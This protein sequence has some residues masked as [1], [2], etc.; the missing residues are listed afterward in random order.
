M[1]CLRAVVMIPV[2][3]VA[4]NASAQVTEVLSVDSHGIYGNYHSWY[5]SFAANDRFVAFGSQATNLVPGDTNGFADV[6]VRDRLQGT[7]ERASVGSAGRQGDGHSVSSSISGTGRWVAFASAA[8][9]LVPGDTNR[10]MDVFVRDRESGATERISVDP[11]GVQSDGDSLAPAIS[12]D[13]RFVAFVSAATNLVAGDTNAVADVFVRDLATGRTERISVD[14]S[15]MEGNQASGVNTPS[16][17]ADGR[18]VAFDSLARNLVSGDSNGVCD[19]FVRDRRL[20]VT[21]RVSVASN[22]WQGNRQSATPSISADGRFVAFAGD[23]TNLVTTDRGF[24]WDVFLHDRSSGTTERLS[25]APSGIQG[26]DHSGS[27]EISADGRSVAFVSFA[28]NLDPR[29]NVW[30][31]NIYVRDLVRDVT[32]LAS[33]GVDGTQASCCS[34]QYGLAVSADGRFVAFESDAQD[35]VPAYLGGAQVYIRDRDALGFTSLCAPGV[36][37]VTPCPCSNPASQMGPGCDNSAGTGGALLTAAGIAYVSRDELTFSTRGETPTALSV[38]VQADDEFATGAVYGQG[39]RCGV[40]PLRRLFTRS[41]V[42]GSIRVPDPQAGDPSVT[43][44]SAAVGSAIQAGES[45]W[46][47]VYYRDPVVL[48]GCPPTSVFNVTQ[49]GRIDWSL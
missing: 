21:E 40:G 39:V 27:P 48:G 30:S 26:N 24:F 49:T 31:W 10:T 22:G 43:R 14:S 34:G 37:T 25:I 9:N 13:G 36:G 23:A 42:N 8:A 5:P 6:F 4:G 20:T 28:T 29:A 11:G 35:L 3:A 32:E 46:Y 12:A 15:G 2:I 1:R 38:L 41:A 17:S 33:V 16:I 18:F 7:T 19:V 44:R 45:R 47:F